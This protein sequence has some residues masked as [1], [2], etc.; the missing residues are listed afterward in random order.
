MGR[1]RRSAP[2]AL[3][4]ASSLRSRFFLPSRPRNAGSGISASLRARSTR[5]SFASPPRGAPAAKLIVEALQANKDGFY[6]S[7]VVVAVS[8]CVFVRVC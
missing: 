2:S 5:S 3:A 1:S 8:L 4:N 7:I 6:I